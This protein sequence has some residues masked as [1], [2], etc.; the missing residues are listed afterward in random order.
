[1]EQSF[2]QIIQ[3]SLQNNILQI[4][5]QFIKQCSVNMIHII[6]QQLLIVGK[7]KIF[8]QLIQINQKE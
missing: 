5:L 6:I 4:N 8:A 1:F 3:K 7:I 2:T